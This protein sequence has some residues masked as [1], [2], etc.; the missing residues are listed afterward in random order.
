MNVKNVFSQ[1]VSYLMSMKQLRQFRIRL[2]SLNYWKHYINHSTKFYTIIQRG[3][4]IN[5]TSRRQTNLFSSSEISAESFRCHFSACMNI[6][7]SKRTF[8]C[9]ELISSAS[10]SPW[11]LI[12]KLFNMSFTS[13][14]VYVVSSS[15]KYKDMKNKMHS[16]GQLDSNGSVP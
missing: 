15:L 7:L 4:I 14:I 13:S 2:P 16:K 6:C 1:Y 3:C 8:V 9:A 11:T 10:S 12:S 5:F